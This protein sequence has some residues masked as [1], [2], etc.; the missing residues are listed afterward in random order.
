MALNF[1]L[2]PSN[3]D[4]YNAPNGVTYVYDSVSGYWNVQAEDFSSVEDGSINPAKLSAGAPV[5]TT[6]Y[7]VGVN[8]ANPV[9]MFHVT[10][11]PGTDPTIRVVDGDTSGYYEY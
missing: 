3:G 2:N 6:D 10:G 9:T 4:L 7:K 5:W 11:L 1:P 8:T